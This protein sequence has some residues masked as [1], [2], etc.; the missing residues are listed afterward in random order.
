MLRSELSGHTLRGFPA[1]HKYDTHDYDYIDPHVGKIVTDGGRLLE[2]GEKSNY[3]ADKYRIRTTDKENLEASNQLFIRLVEEIHRRGMRII[4]DGV[5]NHCGS[6]NKW[7]D[8]E[9]IYD[10]VEGYQP[11]AYMSAQSPYRNYFL[12]HNNNDSEWP[13]NASYDGWWGHDTLPKLN[14][15]DSKELE[16]YVL[17]VAKKW[18]SP[19]YNVDGWRL[20][21]AADLGRSN[22]YNHEFWKKFRKV[23]KDANPNAL[24]LAEHYGD[25]REWLEGDEWDTVM[26][27]DA[28]MEPLTWFLTGMEKHSDEYRED[29]LG[30]ADNFVNAMKHHMASMM[31]PSLQTAMNQLS[32]HDHSRFL[33]RTNHKVGRVAELGPEAANQG[34]D[35]AIMRVAIVMQMTWIGAPTLYYGDEAGVCGFTD[36]DNRRTYPWGREN[37][38]MISFYR[39][40][41]RIHRENLALKKGSLKMLK[42]GPGLLAYGRFWGDEQIIVIINSADELREI[43]VNVM[44]AEVKEGSNMARIM[45]SYVEGYIGVFDEYVVKDGILSL[46][47]GP[48]SAIVLKNKKW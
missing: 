29:L 42:W 41:I 17:G 31:T 8:R 44:P 43:H 39:E 35:L 12:F 22:E 7:M 36:P 13:Q 48:K 10:Q 6:F 15:E 34:V 21:V 1:N 32:N 18:V 3:H 40:M 33:T 11:G 25:P 37:K 30:N 28:F 38:E 2:P 4:I 14:Y 23:V 19:P 24:I 45:Y 9:M 27:Y 16:E 46:M 26:N 47:M 5:F 20:D